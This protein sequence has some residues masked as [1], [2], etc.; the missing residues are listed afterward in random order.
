MPETRGLCLSEEQ[1]VSSVCIHGVL[2]L[3]L[4]KYRILSVY[5]GVLFLKHN[6]YLEG[7]NWGTTDLLE[8]ERSNKSLHGDVRLQPF[9]FFTAYQGIDTF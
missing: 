6:R 1:T 9:W 7:Q 5:H 8:C 4:P 2:L 3:Q